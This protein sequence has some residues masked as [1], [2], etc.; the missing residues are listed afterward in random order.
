MNIVKIMTQLLKLNEK[1]KSENIIYQ[2][3]NEN[4]Y[5]AL[6][7][8]NIFIIPSENF[9]IDMN[10][11]KHRKHNLKELIGEDK[12]QF[13]VKTN[14]QRIINKTTAIKIA[15]DDKYA[16]VDTKLLTEYSN[17][18]TYTI[19]D[20]KSPVYIYKDDVLEGVVLPIEIRM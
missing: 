8:Y 2:E 3:I 10:K 18:C 7:S 15:S 5:L 12:G 9:F 14:E 19:T 20:D 4:V 17:N 16:W 6:N 13:A 1:E 11:I